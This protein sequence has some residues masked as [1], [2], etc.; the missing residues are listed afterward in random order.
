LLERLPTSQP[1]TWWIPYNFVVKGTPDFSK[2]T[3]DGWIP[4]GTTSITVQPSASQNWTNDDWIVFN[5]QESS[6]YRVNYDARLWEL[7]IEELVDGDYTKIHVLNRA[8]LIDDSSNFA[9]IKLINY[10][11]VFGLMEYLSNEM[12]YVPWVSAN[13]V[14]NLVDRVMASLG[15]YEHLQV[16]FYYVFSSACSNI[17]ALLLDLHS[18]CSATNL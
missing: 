13:R 12:D 3:P 17:F 8:Q 9:S 1:Q 10:D 6:Y 18:S 15:N 7:I 2:T 4:Q 16:R 14:L 5:K 11:V